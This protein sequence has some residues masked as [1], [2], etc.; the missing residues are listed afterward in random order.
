MQI[1]PAHTAAELRALNA[2]LEQRL[3]ERT[4]ELEASNRE[5]ESFAYSV[6]HDL[7]AP[8][9]IIDGFS[10]ILEDDYAGRVDDEGRDALRR[11][12]AAAQG[13]AEQIDDLLKLARVSRAE[14][15]REPVDLSTLARSIAGGLEAASPARSVAFD[16]A[17]GLVA[18]G[19]RAQLALL[20]GNLIGN[21][22]KFTSRHSSARIEIG[23]AEKAGDSVYFVR[24]DGAGFDMADARRLFT[25]F[26]RLH[27]VR[28]FPGTGI[29]LA[30]VQRVVRRHGGR[31]WAESAVEKGAT[32]HFTLPANG[33][34]Q[35]PQREE[36]HA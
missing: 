30:I 5:F 36:A 4:T 11:V 31:A 32:I 28:E 6:S 23:V 18:W 13:M 34:A 21:A 3:H 15:A 22:W 17:P 20:L 35:A 7:R 12:R 8:L 9:R 24:D 33:A 27:G 29:G 2:A 25:P 14:L 19:D 26:Q 1:G 16:I 10:K